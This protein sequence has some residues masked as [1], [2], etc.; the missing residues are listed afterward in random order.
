MIPAGVEMQRYSSL[1]ITP[2]QTEIVK[3]C[4]NSLWESIYNE[5]K[6]AV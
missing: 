5:K 6:K 2:R 4:Y 3:P 1:Y